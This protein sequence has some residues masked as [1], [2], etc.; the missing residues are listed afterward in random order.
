MLKKTSDIYDLLNIKNEKKG[1]DQDIESL[2]K[3]IK[4]ECSVI[5]E[6]SDIFI[7]N[8]IIKIK[9]SSNNKF[10][11]LLNLSKI[12]TGIKKVFENKLILEL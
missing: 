9:T 3:I 12:N 7:K 1:F 5:L 10:V 4:E 8:N 11:M 6:K 2:I